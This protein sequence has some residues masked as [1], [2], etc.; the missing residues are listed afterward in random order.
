MSA[1]DEESPAR[2]RLLRLGAAAPLIAL[3]PLLRLV[4]ANA[5]QAPTTSRVFSTDAVAGQPPEIPVIFDALGEIRTIYTMDLVDQIL[6]S[7]TRA[8]SIT[9]TDPKVPSETAFD[10]MMKD[11]A[12]YNL[13]FKEHQSHYR[14][15]RSVADVEIARRENKLAVFYNIQNSTPVER[16]LDKVALLKKLGLTAIQLTYN[17]QNYAGTGCL[18]G[19]D[20]GLT[21]FGGELIEQMADDRVLVDLSHAGMKTMAGA[22]AASPRP[23]IISHTACKALRSHPRNTTD[24]NIRALADRGGV[25]GMAQMRTFMTDAK[26]DNL[27]VYFDHILHAVKVAGVDHV[28]IGSDRDHRVIPNTEEEVANLLREEGAQFQPSDWPLYLEKLNGPRRME[29]VREGLRK[30]K[31]SQS[32]IDK[33]MGMNIYRIYQNVIG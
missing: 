3:A 4:D 7:G 8:I 17:D 33:I 11:L 13:Y 31:L 15:A 1:R 24:E 32:A 21:P 22:I 30:R 28:G 25:M 27:D 26:M 20:T 29:V 5:V 12:E 19:D 6:A 16:Q 2:R 23:V 9:L 10:L 14:V 18:A